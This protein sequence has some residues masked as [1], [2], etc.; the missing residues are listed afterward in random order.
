MSTVD[1][2]REKGIVMKAVFKWVKGEDVSSP[3]TWNCY[4][5]FERPEY[6]SPNANMLTPEAIAELED[7]LPDPSMNYLTVY[8]SGISELPFTAEVGTCGMFGG[9]TEGKN[10]ADEFAA[11]RV[12]QE[13]FKKNFFPEIVRMQTIVEIN[14]E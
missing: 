6:M 1:R 8:P 11:F 7:T 10:V 12:A 13:M 2:Q 14:G 4:P 3:E 5:E 9:A